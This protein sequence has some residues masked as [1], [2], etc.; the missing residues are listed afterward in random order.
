MTFDATN[1][2]V[3][4]TVTVTGVN[5]DYVRNDVGTVSVSVNDTSSVAV[6]YNTT[7][8]MSE[9]I[10]VSYTDDDAAMV[11]VD[12]SGISTIPLTLPEN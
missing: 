3:A 1:W 11:V 9:D 7:D 4:Q 2:N 5:D 8:V 10:A 6:E 12:P